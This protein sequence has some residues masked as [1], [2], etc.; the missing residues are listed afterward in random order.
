MYFVYIFDE[1]AR[2]FCPNLGHGGYPRWV[3]TMV[4]EGHCLQVP[5]SL[6]AQ[7]P[8][9]P[10]FKVLMYGNSHLRQASFKFRRSPIDIF[11]VIAV[12]CFYL[13]PVFFFFLRSTLIHFLDDGMKCLSYFLVEVPYRFCDSLFVA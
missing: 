3:P 10:D 9:P 12:R 11:F 6:L 13:S 7:A 2:Y 4:R 1:L 8:L 5:R